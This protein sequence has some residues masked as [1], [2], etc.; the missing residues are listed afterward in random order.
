[1][2]RFKMDY[3]DAFVKI[4]ISRIHAS[5]WFPTTRRIIQIHADR[6]YQYITSRVYTTSLGLVVTKTWNEPQRPTTTQQRHTTT[7][8]DPKIWLQRVYSLLKETGKFLIWP[9]F[10][11]VT[12]ENLTIHHVIMYA[13]TKYTWLYLYYLSKMTDKEV[14]YDV[15]IP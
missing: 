14:V 15:M 6:L 8:N 4:Y 10:Y 3:L 9:N 2:V 12:Q 7:Y 1:M 11:L 13:T 5:I